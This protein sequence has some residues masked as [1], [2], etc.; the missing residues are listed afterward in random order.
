MYP[1]T[2]PV[3]QGYGVNEDYYKQFNLTLRS[4]GRGH[5]GIDFACKCGTPV[6]AAHSGTIRYRGTLGNYGNYI[7]I[8][9]DK[10]YGTG[11]AH[12]QGFA[13]N[14][15]QRVNEGDVIG[16]VGSTGNSTGCHLHFNYYRTYGQWVYDNPAEILGIT[17]QKLQDMA[18]QSDLID[19]VYKGFFGPYRSG[20]QKYGADP[21]ALTQRKNQSR[22]EII[23]DLAKSDEYKE[24]LRREIHNRTGVYPPDSLI[25][26]NAKN[27]TPIPQLLAQYM[28]DRYGEKGGSSDAEKKLSEIKA[29]L[30]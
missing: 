16:Y 27:Q 24:I 23:A 5:E 25:E 18:N 29:I 19:E 11:Y 10:G 21:G 9:H 1:V 28:T 12:L 14:L 4:G 26:A 2:C 6:K 30:N 20:A 15:N 22:P 3:S 13:V 17:E 8:Q 7:G